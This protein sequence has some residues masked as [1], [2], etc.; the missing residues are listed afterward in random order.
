MAM[1]RHEIPTHL[2]VEDRAFYGLTA[3]QLMWLTVGCAGG[4]GLWTQWPAL[5]L[6]SRLALAAAC[7]AL[8]TVLAFVRPHGRSLED[9]AVVALR[10]AA[11]PRRSVWRPRE[12]TLS[13]WRSDGPDWAELA[14]R[15]SWAPPAGRQEGAP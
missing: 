5:P 2:R 3:R 8:A 10:Y 1:T 13:V 11:I 7:L 14:P 15:P 12:P 9:W 4:Y 6:V